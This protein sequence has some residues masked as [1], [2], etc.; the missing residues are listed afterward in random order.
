MRAV[1]YQILKERNPWVTQ[2][3]QFHPLTFPPSFNHVL[4]GPHS[5]RPAYTRTTCTITNPTR[6]LLETFSCCLFWRFRCTLVLKARTGSCTESKISCRRNNWYTCKII[7]LAQPK[8]I[9]I[10]SANC[11]LFD[12]HHFKPLISYV[13][14][15]SNSNYCGIK[16]DLNYP[17]H[18]R[19]GGYGWEILWRSWIHQFNIVTSILSKSVFWG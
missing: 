19:A 13:H 7:A 18:D 3:I 17:R 6:R 14:Q 8:R 4:L 12:R 16:V 5:L 15:A 1:F 9:Q 2:L 10:R 11:L